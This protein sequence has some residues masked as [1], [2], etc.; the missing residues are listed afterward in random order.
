MKNILANKK[1]LN[2]IAL[3]FLVISLSS[4]SKQVEELGSDRL[5]TDGPIYGISMFYLIWMM[6][7]S[8]IVIICGVTG[9]TPNTDNIWIDGKRHTITT[10]EKTE[11]SSLDT[12][13][14][15][16]Y[17]AYR[18]PLSLVLGVILQTLIFYMTGKINIWLD[19][20]IIALS[21]YATYW[22]VNNCPTIIKILFYIL[23]ITAIVTLTY[24][25]VIF[26]NAMGEM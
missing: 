11:P 9:F 21:Q 24:Y 7:F 3:L 17:W 10:Y 12:I 13:L 25:I 1:W 6:L 23:L 22:F 15:M 16:L 5:F 18:K 14:S 2:I 4:C 26:I 20:I 8:I 19:I